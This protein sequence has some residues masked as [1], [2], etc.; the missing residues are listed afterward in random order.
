MSLHTLH[1]VQGLSHQ[2]ER[3][4]GKS[5]IL[6]FS[7]YF[8]LSQIIIPGLVSVV[9]HS[10][11]Y[12][13]S[14]LNMVYYILM[15]IIILLNLFVFP[16]CYAG[17]PMRRDY[18]GSL[19]EGIIA[20]FLSGCLSNAVIIPLGSRLLPYQSSGGQTGFS[21][22]VELLKWLLRDAFPYLIVIAIIWVILSI[23]FGAVGWFIATKLKK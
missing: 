22:F 13:V 6:A 23:L 9:Y 14:I 8:L 17:F 4:F 3:L 11:F 15:V 7:S 2:R 12:N 20:S 16:F 10:P 1:I 19:V 18:N 21:H 5:D